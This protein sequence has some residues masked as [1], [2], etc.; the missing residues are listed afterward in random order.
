MTQMWGAYE[1]YEAGL[2][3]ERQYV[4]GMRP[5]PLDPTFTPQYF[6][7]LIDE[8]LAGEKRSV[9]GLM[10]SA[11]LR[12]F[13]GHARPTSQSP[14][15]E[16]ASAGAGIK[17]LVRSEMLYRLPLLTI[18]RTPKATIHSVSKANNTIE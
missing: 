15:S 8:L 4:K 10:F 12:Q 3:Q 16:W 13:N 11:S 17:R 6:S 9:I 18:A 7:A 5:T 1:L 2:E 14:I